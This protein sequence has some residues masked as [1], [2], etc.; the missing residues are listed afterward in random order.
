MDI[1]KFK[2]VIYTANRQRLE[3]IP[4]LKVFNR[5]FKNKKKLYLKT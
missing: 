4:K 1:S 3:I 5:Q 2:P